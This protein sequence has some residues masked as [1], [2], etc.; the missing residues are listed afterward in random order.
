LNNYRERYLQLYS[1][2]KP[3]FNRAEFIY[4]SILYYEPKTL[5]DVGCGWGYLVK[6]ANE[7]GI[8]AKGLDFA[9]PGADF[10]QRATDPF[11][12]DA[13][14]MVT[15]LDVFEHLYEPEID[16]VIKEMRRV[17]KG[18]LI[19]SICSRASVNTFDDGSNLHNTIEPQQWWINR[20]ESHG[21]EHVKT[22]DFVELFQV[23]K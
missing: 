23:F 8:D 19:V 13:V 16:I 5:L 18:L 12:M 11:P 10:K 14:D 4:S 20:I 15:S 6:W 21:F 3:D 22:L 7:N 2:E 17:C 9:A 1:H